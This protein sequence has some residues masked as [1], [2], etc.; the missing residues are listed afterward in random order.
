MQKKALAIDEQL[1]R[2]EGMANTYGNLW[3]IYQTRGDLDRAEEMHKKALAINEKLGRFSG[4]SMPASRMRCCTRSVVRIV[5]VSP[6]VM[7]TTRP[8]IQ[9]AR[10]GTPMRTR[11]RR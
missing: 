6:S 7:A 1:G 5:R 3:V 4:V 2:Q 9:S 8:I 11:H 10:A